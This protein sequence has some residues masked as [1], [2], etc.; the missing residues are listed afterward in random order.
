MN[1]NLL[2]EADA[3]LRRFRELLPEATRPDVFQQMNW[4]CDSA[5][6]FIAE[7]R[8]LLSM[9]AVQHDSDVK[10]LRSLEADLKGAELRIEHLLEAQ[11]EKL[12][13]PR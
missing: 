5:R 10:L 3:A 7:A 1:T 8:G 2:L 13:R 11:R 6:L 4:L 12:L 9:Q